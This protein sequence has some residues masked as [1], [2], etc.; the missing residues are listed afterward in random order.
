M[1]AGS[2]VPI[3]G[4]RLA[5][6]ASAYWMLSLSG[7]PQDSR[8]VLKLSSQAS[9]YHSGLSGRMQHP[10]STYP[11]CANSISSSDGK[12]P[13]AILFTSSLLSHRGQTGVRRGFMS[14]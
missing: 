6:P 11:S 7:S 2:K 10:P 14:Q 5:V 1:T 4:A 3:G 9:Q 12:R 13:Y 8:H